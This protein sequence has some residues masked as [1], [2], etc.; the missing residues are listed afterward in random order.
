MIK[1]VFSLLFVVLFVSCTPTSSISKDQIIQ[2]YYRGIKENCYINPVLLTPAGPI[3][4]TTEYCNTELQKSK[5][6]KFYEKNKDNPQTL[7]SAYYSGL[8]DGCLYNPIG[9]DNNDNFI[10]R[11]I[12]YCDKWVAKMKTLSIF[13]ENI[14]NGD[15][16]NIPSFL[17][18]PQVE[19]IET[20]PIGNG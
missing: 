13:K 10:F 15:I 5:N 18:T 2:Q 4:L 17:Q 8:Y 6:E 16:I 1:L 14:T 11:T 3:F 12:Q 9:A 19:P 20:Q 7:E